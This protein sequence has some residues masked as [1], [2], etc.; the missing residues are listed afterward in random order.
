VKAASS[1]D[2]NVKST[3]LK[4]D[5]TS[6]KAQLEDTFQLLYRQR[7]K[8]HHCGLERDLHNQQKILGPLPLATSG[9]TNARKDISSLLA[10]FFSTDAWEIKCEN[11][12]CS[13]FEKPKLKNRIS[14]SIVAAPEVLMIQLKCF[15]NQGKVTSK[16]NPNINY[17]HWL[18]LSKHASPELL[19][20]EGD[21]KYK[22]AS[23][24][25][26][27]GSSLEAGHYVGAYVGPNGAHHISDEQV[28]KTSP[29]ALLPESNMKGTPYILT[30]VRAGARSDGDQLPG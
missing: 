2:T 28:Q 17:G 15:R 13:K 20:K 1:K 30:Y 23:V 24:I 18:D 29:N 12:A 7:M 19:K 11:K 21:L 8:C 27:Q 10:Q 26:H 5:A 14:Q 3:E 25:L 16:K 9:T 6:F 4:L 22:L